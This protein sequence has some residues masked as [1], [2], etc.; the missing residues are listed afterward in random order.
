[1]Y[2]KNSE[3]KKNQRTFF[4]VNC[5]QLSLTKRISRNLVHMV[6]LFLLQTILYSL[7]LPVTLADWI[8]LSFI[9]GSVCLVFYTDNHRT[10]TSRY[11]TY[12][13]NWSS[14][15]ARRIATSFFAS[16]PQTVRAAVQLVMCMSVWMSLR[17]CISTALAKSWE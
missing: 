16:P 9:A 15:M 7:P 4:F 5:S 3:F 10:A 2:P 8:A 6:P 12:R 17:D 14:H 1:M 11:R 13:L